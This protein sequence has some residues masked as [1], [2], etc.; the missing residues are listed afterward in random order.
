MI[1]LQ[2][3]VQ[4][5]VFHIRRCLTDSACAMEIL[6]TVMLSFGWLRL[7]VPGRAC[8][9]PIRYHQPLRPTGYANTTNCLRPLAHARTAPT[10]AAWPPCW[11]RSRPVLATCAAC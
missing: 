1:D 7:W 8:V 11:V 6:G 9:T 10:P 5:A 3:T 4:H 2:A